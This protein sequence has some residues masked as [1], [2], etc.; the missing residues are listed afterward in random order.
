MLSRHAVSRFFVA[1]LLTAGAFL[2]AFP[3]AAG[4]AG[5][6]AEV[7]FVRDLVPVFVKRCVSCHGDRKDSGSLRL[8]T[9]EQMMRGGASGDPSIVAGHPEKSELFR[10]ITAADENDRMPQDDD[11]LSAA[12]I[13]LVRDWIAQGA[14]FDGPDPKA[15]F[16][17]LLP[18]REH[19]AAPVAYRM[20]VPVLTLALAPN[21]KE[22]AVG[23]YNE[24]T[25][26][27]TTNGKLLRRLGHLPQRIQAL[28]FNADGTQLLVGGGTPGDYGEL[29][30][31]EFA[32]GRKIRV[33]D[34]FD[35]VVLSASF[36]NDGQRI[37]AGSADFTARVYEAAGGKRLWSQ[38]LHSDWVTS[39]SFSAD[40]RF[41]ASA[42][43]DK[44]VKIYEADS[45]T[46]FT[47]YN[48]HNQILG[49]HAGQNP[50]YNVK[51]TPD[52]PVAVSAGKGA[53]I[54][55]W[56][57]E[58]AR[59]ENGTAADMELRFRKTGHARYLEHGFQLEVFAMMVRGNQVFAASADGLV[60][61]F[62]LETLQEVRPYAGHHDWVYALDCDARATKLATGGYD[63][64]VRIWDTATGNC[65]VAFKAAPGFTPKL[66]SSR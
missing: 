15:N 36:Q 62:N 66:A 34:T 38:K 44:T 26:W 19:P 33:L 10:L 49:A 1:P 31:V 39:V 37:A 41:L 51:F 7:S 22:V 12:Q 6:P 43:K 45:G 50:V 8:H 4:A 59:D 65:I 5:A 46:L 14:K 28:A 61:Q 23:G 53:W 17:S 18:P 54:Q 58:K 35:D 29:T 11:A 25:V 20:P 30:L 2:A 47:T 60:K 55:L 57:P 52:S 40:K 32:T 64:E 13:K 56:E 3:A 9:F 21:G 48:G 63:G 27:D 42:S 24:V 16:K